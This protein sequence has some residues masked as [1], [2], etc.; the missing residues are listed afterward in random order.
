[1]WWQLALESVV[2]RLSTSCGNSKEMASLIKLVTPGFWLAKV[3]PG[4]RRDGVVLALRQPAAG[5]DI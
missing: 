2:K 3:N 5:A 4:Y 1:M